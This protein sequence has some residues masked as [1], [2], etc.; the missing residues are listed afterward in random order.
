VLAGCWQS[1][2]PRIA[3]VL[4]GTFRVP[5]DP[6]DAPVAVPG[7][8]RLALEWIILFG[9]AFALYSSV[10]KGW[11]IALAVILALHYATADDRVL[12]LIRQN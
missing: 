9:G 6:R 2:F 3:I 12:W 5:G 4:W 8:D 11:G 10:Q 7:I 1:A